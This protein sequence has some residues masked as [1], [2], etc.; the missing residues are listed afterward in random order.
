MAVVNIK[1]YI[2]KN[3]G[4]IKQCDILKSI[5]YIEYIREEDSVIEVSKIIFP[6]V[7]VLSQACD[8]EQ[9]CSS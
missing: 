5:D 9:D 8:L 3:Y 1:T 6:Y 7:I 2:D 4:C